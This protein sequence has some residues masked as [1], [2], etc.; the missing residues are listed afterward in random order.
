MLSSSLARAV[1][2][3]ALTTAAAFGALALS[4]HPGTASMGVLLTISLF[5]IVVT[6]LGFFP[7]LL[8]VVTGRAAPAAGIGVGQGVI[9]HDPALR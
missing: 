7:A 2:F 9:D 6:T 3:S 1:L 8:F 5:W 4:S